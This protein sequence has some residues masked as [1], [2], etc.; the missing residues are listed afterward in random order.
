M[1]VTGIALLVIAFALLLFAGT[2][3]FILTPPGAG[4]NR[5][6]APPAAPLFSP[7]LTLGMAAVAGIAGAGILVFGGRGYVEKTGSAPANPN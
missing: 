1:K 2:S 4:E 7:L 6:D 5:P 3:H